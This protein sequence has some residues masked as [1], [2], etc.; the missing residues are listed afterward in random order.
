MTSGA[1]GAASASGAPTMSGA[2]TAFEDWHA[3]HTLLMTYAERLDG[4]SFAEVGALFE[5]AMYRIE[6]AGGAGSSSFRGAVE[7]EGFCR[8]TRLYPDGTPRTRHL[9]TNVN[10]QV[11]GE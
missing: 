2:P 3:I 1:S 9:V 11:D 6:H 8:G 10:I 5:E 7:V 4:G